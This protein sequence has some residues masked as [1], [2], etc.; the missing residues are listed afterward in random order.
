MLLSVEIGCLCM[1]VFA[2]HMLA[3]LHSSL[4]CTLNTRIDLRRGCNNV[5]TA[6]HS[7]SI[8]NLRMQNGSQYA[9][10]R[11]CEFAA[12]ATESPR[13]AVFQAA[14]LTNSGTSINS[15]SPINSGSR[16]SIAAALQE[17]AFQAVIHAS[18]MSICRSSVVN[19]VLVPA[20]H[21]THILC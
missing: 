19:T 2:E 1:Y 11:K 5:W 6:Q 17:H 20:R 21:S 13:I 9:L 12:I 10:C 3:S 18:E 15:G 14:Y 16:P 7:R 4:Q 8:V